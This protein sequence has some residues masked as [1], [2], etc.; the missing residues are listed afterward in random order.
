MP[1][2]PTPVKLHPAILQDGGRAKGEMGEVHALPRRLWRVFASLA[3]AQ[4]WPETSLSGLGTG[5]Q[6]PEADGLSV[7]F[8]SF[9]MLGLGL[10]ENQNWVEPVSTT[11]RGDGYDRAGVVRV[12]RRLRC[13][14]RLWMNI[15]ANTKCMNGTLPCIPRCACACRP[16]WAQVPR[17]HQGPGDYFQALSPHRE[18]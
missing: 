12:R 7:P 16:T 13:D 17:R 18:S 6:V 9:T 4:I 5:D 8:A 2:L 10:G 3:G 1:C 11:Y 15:A 14:S